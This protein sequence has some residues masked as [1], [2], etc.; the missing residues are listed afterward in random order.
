MQHNVIV[1][2]TAGLID[3]NHRY[4]V[5]ISVIEINTVTYLKTTAY[6]M[7]KLCGMKLSV[8]KQMRYKISKN[9]DLQSF[10]TEITIHA[11]IKLFLYSY[12]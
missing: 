11:L 7:N 4:F 1:L 2:T 12:Y 10:D 8:S 6:Y 9:S 5:L 3:R